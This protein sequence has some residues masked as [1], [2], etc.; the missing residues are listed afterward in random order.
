MTTKRSL[1][2]FLQGFLLCA[3]NGSQVA[4]SEPRFALT[5]LEDQAQISVGLPNGKVPGAEKSSRQV[6]GCAGSLA[7]APQVDEQSL[8]FGGFYT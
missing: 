5:N 2:S 3:E 6:T 7:G 4:S 1:E 8:P